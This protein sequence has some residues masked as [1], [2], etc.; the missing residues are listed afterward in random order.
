MLPARSLPTEKIKLFIELEMPFLSTFPDPFS[1]IQ[2]I[3]QDFDLLFRSSLVGFQDF[4]I[5]LCIAKSC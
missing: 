5:L 3:L 2:S 1:M 4:F